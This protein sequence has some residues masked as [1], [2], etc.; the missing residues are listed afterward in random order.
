MPV[1]ISSEEAY[2]AGRAAGLKW[3]ESKDP[4]LRV[5]SSFRWAKIQYPATADLD[6]R[7]ELIEF[8]RMRL[9]ADLDLT[10]FPECRGL[11]QVVEVER[12]GFRNACGDEFAMAFEYNWHWLISRRFNARYVG[13]T[14]P[15]AQCTDIWFANTREGG[16]I[17]ASNRDDVRENY[18]AT[19]NKIPS[20][21]SPGNER[22]TGFA[23]VGG[24][25]SAVLCD[26]EPEEW[27]PVRLDWIDTRGI[28]S[29]PEYVEFLG[30]YRDFWG[31]CNSIFVDSQ[32]NF[33]AIEK[34]NRRMGVRY[35]K[36][37]ACAI[38]ACAY[39][40]P[41]M[42][43]FKKERDALSFKV[44]G[45]TTDNPDAAY[46]NGCERRYRRLLK[47]VDEEN[48]RGPTLLGAARIVLDH[49]VPFPDC[50]CV[51]GEK[52][53]PDEQLQNWTLI[54]FARCV[55]GPNRRMLYWQMDPT[56]PIPVYR[57]KSHLIVGQGIAENPSWARELAEAGD[58]GGPAQ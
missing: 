49:A 42:N 1:R 10:K 3:A 51:A 8:D 34:A 14:P 58:I 20:S 16:P 7:R 43:A 4:T 52:G 5:Q 40:T 17:H 31:P 18:T 28:A 27:F 37:G 44:R 24:V 13:R 35:A 25:S 47:L 55:V 29:L 46:W 2:M 38:T 41:E 12:R 32:W 39:L 45:W 48:R 57:T 22:F 19:S 56:K 54:S 6:L 11:R 15:P 26:E 53:H 30:R 50:I 23:Q 21:G 9:A 36:D 33:V